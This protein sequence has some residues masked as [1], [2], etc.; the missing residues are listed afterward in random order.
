MR[1]H[2]VKAIIKDGEVVQ[3]TTPAQVR[4]VIS[5]A[6]ARQITNI[7]QGV[8]TRGSGR[9]A[10]V[11]GYS[12]AGKTGTAQKFDATL[13]NYSA[14][15]AIA[16]FVGYLPAERPRAVILV[17][18]DEPQ[19]RVAWGGVAAA[20][21]FSAIAQHTMRYLRVPPEGSH[22]HAAEVSVA[23]LERSSVRPAAVSLSVGNFVENVREMLRGMVA[24]LQSYVWGQFLSVD[25]KE[26]RKGR[27]K[28]ERSDR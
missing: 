26:A 5:E 15:K 27:K 7:L 8:V 14:Q 4:R 23:R 11:D 2:L 6:T 16:S 18:I 13:G 19:T 3:E 17:S 20:P 10:A 28:T 9:A 1:P 21:L 25:P 12:V 24:Q 22:V